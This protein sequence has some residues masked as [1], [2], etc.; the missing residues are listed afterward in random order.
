M[1]LPEQYTPKA[2]QLAS[3]KQ[4]YPSL[5]NGT[6]FC[7]SKTEYFQVHWDSMTI[8]RIT[9][10]FQPSVGRGCVPI[11]FPPSMFCYTTT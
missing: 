2:L 11:A 6:L 4:Q 3:F 5:E 8:Q 10:F 1:G 9:H 7:P